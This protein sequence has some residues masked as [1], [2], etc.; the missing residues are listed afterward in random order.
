MIV[1]MKPTYTYYFINVNFSLDIPMES[2]PCKV[3]LIYVK[4]NIDIYYVF[5]TKY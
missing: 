2:I 1:T 4:S 5:P 3:K